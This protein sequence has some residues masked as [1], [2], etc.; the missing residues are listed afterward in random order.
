MLRKRRFPVPTSI[1]S[2]PKA[3]SV[4]ESFSTEC[5]KNALNDPSHAAPP[6]EAVNVVVVEK[7]VVGNRTCWRVGR[8]HSVTE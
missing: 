6:M 4:R 7:D 1:E 3:A 2:N 8:Q 5:V